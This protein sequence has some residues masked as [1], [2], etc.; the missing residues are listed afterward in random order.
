MKMWLPLIFILLLVFNSFSTSSPLNIS[1]FKENNRTA[2]RDIAGTVTDKHNRFIVGLRVSVTD[3]SKKKQYK[4]VTDKSGFFIFSGLPLGTY[5]LTFE[6]NKAFKPKTVKGVEVSL[7][8]GV[9]YNTTLAT[10]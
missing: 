10:R 2:N 9:M 8:G 1:N 4:T 5:T 7:N 6:G 3:L